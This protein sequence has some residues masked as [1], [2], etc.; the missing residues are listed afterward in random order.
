MFGSHLS[1]AGGLVNALREARRLKMDCVQIFTKNQRQWNAPPLSDAERDDW[2]AMLGSLGWDSPGSG[3]RTVSHNSYLINLASPDPTV[4]EKSIALQRIEMERCEA[5]RIPLLVSHPGAHL[6]PSR[7]ARQPHVLGSAPTA[8]ELDGLNRVVAA[9]D[10]LHAELPGLGVITCLETTAGAGSNLGYDFG[11]LRLIRNA[12]RQ[13]ERLAFCLDTCHVTAAG[14]DMT[15]DAGAA[16]VLDLWDDLCGLENL[17][18]VHVNDSAGAVGSRVDRHAHIGRGACGLA[19]FRAIVNHPLLRAVPM[20]LET[21]KEESDA[22][23]P[24]DLINIRRLRRLQSRSTSSKTRPG[25]ADK[26]LT[27]SAPAVAVNIR[28]PRRRPRTLSNGKK[29]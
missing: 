9:L 1:I 13:P 29:T 17:R 16:A 4:R 28:R 21:P 27:G 7:P 26:G 18:V 15:T 25:R 5:L 3:D 23:V 20:V 19:C 10:R 6:G 24:W 2:L 8:A 14:Y 12:V 22:G 11:H